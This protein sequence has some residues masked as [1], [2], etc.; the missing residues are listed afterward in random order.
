M[1]ERV[2]V[3]GSWNH[4][5]ARAAIVGFVNEVS[6]P[7]S[8][9]YVPPEERVAVFDSDGT[10]WCEKPMPMQLGFVL[11][12]LVAMTQ[13]KPALRKRQ[14]W[15]AACDGDYAWFADVVARGALG[16]QDRTVTDLWLGVMEAF[17]DTTTDQYE[18]A[19]RAFVHE[20]EH[21]ALQRPV[22][23]CVYRP[24]VELMRYLESKQFSIYIAPTGDRDFVGSMA[25]DAFRVPRERIIG[26]SSAF[27]YREDPQRASVVYLARPAVFG[28]N[29]PKR[30]RL[31]KHVGCRPVLAVGNANDDIPMFQL[32]CAKTQPA[33]CLLLN[34]DDSAREFAY[35]EGAEHALDSA[36]QQ[37]WTVVSLRHD[38]NTI[39]G[40][41]R[42]A[43]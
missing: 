32:T 33:L 15:K 1:A 38:W 34:H 30:Q 10:L 43:A 24:M 40:R 9:S 4:G 26:C 5:P 3:L 41:E 8:A 22:R 18:A 31:T 12:R 6:R 23:G 13:R 16:I 20:A 42:D 21:P 14:P 36:D 27:G 37:H 29:D 7:G 25:W 17:G 35:T 39:F 28:E 19:A 11:A 2:P